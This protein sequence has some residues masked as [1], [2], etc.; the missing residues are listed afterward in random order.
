MFVIDSL[1]GSICNLMLSMGLSQQLLGRP[2]AFTFSNWVIGG[3]YSLTH[4][5]QVNRVT[6]GCT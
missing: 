3:A 1:R 6:Q 4:Q 2:F 5:R